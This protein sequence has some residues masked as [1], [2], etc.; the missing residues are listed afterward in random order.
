MVSVV[1]Q[2]PARHGDAR[3]GAARLGWARQ[4]LAWQGM[5]WRGPQRAFHDHMEYETKI[6]DYERV[7]GLVCRR[8]GLRLSPHE[9]AAQCISA[10]RDLI[11]DLEN[12]LARRKDQNDARTRRSKAPGS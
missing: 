3:R 9:N 4:G 1:Q 5:A 8:C 11:A 6:V 10:L 2:G 7:D 12:E